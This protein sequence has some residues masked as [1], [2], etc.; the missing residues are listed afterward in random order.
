MYN[1]SLITL[2]FKLVSTCIGLRQGKITR[3]KYKKYW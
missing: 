3:E 2:Y 1:R